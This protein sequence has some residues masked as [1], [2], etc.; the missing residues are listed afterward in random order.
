MS[1]S[2]ITREI[3]EMPDIQYKSYGV[4]Y[5]GQQDNNFLGRNYFQ[6]EIPRIPNFGRFVQSVTLPQFSFSEL[7]QPTTLGLAPAFPGSGYEFSPLIIG[8]GIDERFL[9]YQEL[10]RWMESMAFLTDTTN[11]PRESHT[12]D[13]TLSIK[14]SAYNEKVRI[15]FVDAFPTV[16]SPLEFTSLEP[17]SSPLLG[18]V[19]F[20]YS[21][22][23][24]V[25]IGV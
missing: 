2:D 22:F 17:S 1:D 15:V 16:I 10:F 18:S 11:L 21:N 25:Q 4:T 24:I 9:G 8:F 14:N 7:T 23:E 13:I 20:N 12:S 6:V 5:D 3:P 19:T